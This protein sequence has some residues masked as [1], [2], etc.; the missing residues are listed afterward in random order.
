MRLVGLGAKPPWLKSAESSPTDLGTE[1]VENNHLLPDLA[2]AH[3]RA[4]LKTG[5]QQAQPINFASLRKVLFFAL[6]PNP[7]DQNPCAQS[8]SPMD[9]MVQ[10]C[11]TS[12]FQAWQQWS[13]M[14]S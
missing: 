14:S 6:I 12:L 4:P 13:R 11:S 2:F 7:T 1:A 5:R 10:G 8:R 9:M 3:F